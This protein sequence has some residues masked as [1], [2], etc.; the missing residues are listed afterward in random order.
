MSVWLHQP[1]QDFQL[2]I[3]DPDL[4]SGELPSAPFPPCLH[5]TLELRQETNRRNTLLDHPGLS[6]AQER[7]LAFLSVGASTR[8]SSALSR[9][10]GFTGRGC[11]SVGTDCG[12]W[13]WALGLQGTFPVTQF[14]GGHPASASTP[15]CC[16]YVEAPQPEIDTPLF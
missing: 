13:N 2:V 1:R 7:V 11:V 9:L 14:T 10:Q 16:S 15:P 6:R 3:P 4:G 5:P 12:L 8:R